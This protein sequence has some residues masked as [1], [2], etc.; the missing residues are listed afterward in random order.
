M[1]QL[2]CIVFSVCEHERCM[3]R[4]VA[5]GGLDRL[6]CCLC[7]VLCAGAV[8][9]EICRLWASCSMYVEGVADR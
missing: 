4:C 2:S 9:L 1:T 5:A 3:T 7:R 6:L 8:L